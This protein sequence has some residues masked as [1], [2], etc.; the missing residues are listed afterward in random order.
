M[1]LGGRVGHVLDADLPLFSFPPLAAA[2]PQRPPSF[3]CQVRPRPLPHPAGVK[4]EV[5]GGCPPHPFPSPSL[6]LQEL[7]VHDAPGDL[8]VPPPT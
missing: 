5:R 4:G 2:A 3:W 1:W 6:P 7:P 8:L